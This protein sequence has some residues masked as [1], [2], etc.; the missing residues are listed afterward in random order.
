[1]KMPTTLGATIDLLFTLTQQRKEL[2]AKIRAIKEQEDAVES[3]LAHT[4]AQ[5]ERGRV[6]V[7]A[8]RPVGP[9]DGELDPVAAERLHPG[10][11]VLEVHDLAPAVPGEGDPLR[12]PC[13]RVSPV[14]IQLQL[15]LRVV[16]HPPRKKAVNAPLIV[17]TDLGQLSFAS[18]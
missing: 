16:Y 15:C 9:Q 5:V 1:M 14:Q 7:E 18:L 13:R 10:R 12:R 2:E 8:A 17:M 3:H 11:A 4:D 6:E